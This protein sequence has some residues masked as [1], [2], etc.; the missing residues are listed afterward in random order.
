MRF[1][2]YAPILHISALTGERAPKV[3]E[4]IDKIAAARRKRMPTPALNKFI[5]EVTA[6]NPPV[7]PGRKHVRILYAAQIGV[8]P[9]SFVFF[10]NVATTFHFSYERFLD[11]QAA[12]AVRLHRLADSHAG[13]PPRQE[14]RPWRQGV[15]RGSVERGKQRPSTKLNAGRPANVSRRADA[16]RKNFGAQVETTA[17]RR[18]VEARESRVNMRS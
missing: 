8:A 13:P 2:D 4:T 18:A 1:L 14:D 17:G 11:Q 9:P 3:L 10:T 5:E 6:A 7:S 16:A 12:R 15:A